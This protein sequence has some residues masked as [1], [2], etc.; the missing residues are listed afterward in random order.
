MH[1]LDCPSQDYA[2]GT[3]YDI[4]SFLGRAATGHP[5]AEVWMGTHPLGPAMVQVEDERRPLSDVS[6]DIP[7]MMKILSAARPLSIQVHPN[8]DLARQGYKEEEA[9]GIPIDSPERLY[10]DANPKPE[11]VYALTTFDT[12]VGFRPTAEILR[13]LGPL[14]HPVV[15]GMREQLMERPGFRGI[16][17]MLER[18]LTSPPS[19]HEVHEIVALCHGRLA[20]GLDIKRAYAS[21]TEIAPHYPGDVGVIVSLLLNRLTLQPGEAAYLGAGIL[22]AHLSGM[23]VE[24]MVN[25]DNVLRAGLTPKHLAPEA[26]VASV[27]AEM[28][29]LARVSPELVGASTDVFEPGDGEFGLAVTQTSPAD[30]DGVLLPV[31]G[32]S[33]LVCT[34]GEVE[35]VS[36]RGQVIRLS[37]GAVMYA[38]YEDGEVRLRGTGEV[39]Q[40]YEPTAEGRR[41]RMLDLV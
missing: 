8:A 5:M 22:H 11:M 28:S 16:V 21:A 25:S 26:V 30:V 14:D 33:I 10:K 24:V 41:R 29:R 27:D 1:L 20:L 23:C 6:G 9:R 4:P 17:R 3:A 18:L 19:V 40:A 37:R 12:L 2:W 15:Q 7:F 36:Q 34:G 38:G 32:R 35:A 13:I 31:T 39:A